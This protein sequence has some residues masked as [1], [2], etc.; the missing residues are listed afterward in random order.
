MGRT[1]PYKLMTYMDFGEAIFDDQFRTPDGS[2]I[3]G[4]MA[5]KAKKM[6]AGA[7]AKE[8]THWRP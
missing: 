2:K 8:Y 3:Q 1:I 5:D 4:P 7:L 6:L